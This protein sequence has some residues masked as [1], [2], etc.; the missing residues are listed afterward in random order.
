MQESSRLISSSTVEERTKIMTFRLQ[1]KVSFELVTYQCSNCFENYQKEVVGNSWYT[2]RKD[3]CPLCSKEQIP[4]IDIQVPKSAQRETKVDPT[5]IS[6][7][8]L[9][10]FNEVD[11][12]YFT[13]PFALDEVLFLISKKLSIFEGKPGLTPEIRKRI[14]QLSNLVDWQCYALVLHAQQCLDPS[15][16]GEA[17]SLSSSEQLDET[18]TALSN[19]ATEDTAASSAFFPEVKKV[20]CSHPT[21]R[22]SQFCR[23]AKN[24][25][26]HCQLCSTVQESASDKS[27]TIQYCSRFQEVLEYQRLFHQI[28]S[29][30]SGT[31]EP[32]LTARTEKEN[33]PFTTDSIQV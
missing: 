6:R 20:P 30:H 14:I 28:A 26:Q 32:S 17:P 8:N 22:Q 21:T 2:L 27:C 11:E 12:Q 7:S 23:F 13:L 18:I 3:I 10:R 16:Q 29:H 25:C 19:C 33:R 5:P 4:F 1:E 24:L 9:M 15:L 31:A